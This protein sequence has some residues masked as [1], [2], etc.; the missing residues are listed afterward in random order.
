MNQYVNEDMAWLRLQDFQREAENRRLAARGRRP[1]L[2]H[3][4]RRRFARTARRLAA[5]S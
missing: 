2:I 3:E 1:A 4:L 5:G